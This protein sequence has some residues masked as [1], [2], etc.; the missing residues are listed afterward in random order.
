M[1]EVYLDRSWNNKQKVVRLVN[2]VHTKGKGGL[3]GLIRCLEEEE[4]HLGHAELAETLK[5]GN[6]AH[7]K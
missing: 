4:T 5:K 7:T 2:I 1:A 6:I 3:R